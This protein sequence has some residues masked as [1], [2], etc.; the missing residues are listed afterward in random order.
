MG[1]EQQRVKILVDFLENPVELRPGTRLDIR[2]I[3]DARDE[4]LVIP[5]R[6]TFRHDGGWAVFKIDGGSAVVQPVEIGL[7]N[8]KRAEVLSGLTAGD[9][10]AAEPGNDLQDGGAVS[11]E[12][13]IG[14]DS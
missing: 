10:I 5:E 1:I 9:R 3:T 13:M 8:D 7:K 14:L 12:G 4:T 2:V 11:V 6:A